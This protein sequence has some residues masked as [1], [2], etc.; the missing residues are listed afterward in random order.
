MCSVYF[1]PSTSWPSMKPLPKSS[2]SAGDFGTE[3]IPGA[4]GMPGMPGTLGAWGN[5]MV[6]AVF[7]KWSRM[8]AF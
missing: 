6:W 4:E 7:F 3:G 2:T 5:G 8:M 1:L